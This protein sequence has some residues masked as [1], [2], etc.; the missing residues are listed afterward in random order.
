MEV[1]FFINRK[2]NNFYVGLKRGLSI[3]VSGLSISGDRKL[4]TLEET[5]KDFE[6]KGYTVSLY[7]E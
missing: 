4:A 5:K 6:N 2:K 7:E 1:I 3:Q